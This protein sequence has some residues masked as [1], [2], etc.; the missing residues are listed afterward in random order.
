MNIVKTGFFILL[1]GHKSCN[2]FINFCFS[3]YRN[4]FYIFIPVRSLKAGPTRF[5]ASERGTP[6]PS[7]HKLK[8]RQRSEVSEG[9]KTKDNGFKDL[10]SWES[11]E[12]GP[13]V[14]ED[15]LYEFVES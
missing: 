1:K 13:Y 8:D 11:T 5:N 4:D 12:R 7:L 14:F 6:K 9:V 3:F 15:R 2:V 10:N